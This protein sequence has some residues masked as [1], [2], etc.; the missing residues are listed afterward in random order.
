M[1]T[2]LIIRHAKSSWGNPNFQDFDR[3]LNNRGER[4]APFMAKL[5][6]NKSIK[7]DVIVSS[8]ANRAYATAIEFAKAFGYPEK[9]INMDKG[10]YSHGQGHILSILRNLASNINTICIFGHNPDLTYLATYLSGQLFDNVP[11]CG[12]VC[13]DFDVDVW[14]D[15]DNQNGTLRFFEYPGKHFKKD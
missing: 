9:K 3:P 11:T 5:I 14:G 1:K 15:I 2:L 10:I 8:P 7:P 13:I 4:D 12:V 6:S